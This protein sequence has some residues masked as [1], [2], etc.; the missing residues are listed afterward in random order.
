MQIDV[1]VFGLNALKAKFQN[2]QVKN[3]NWSQELFD[4]GIIL[5][6][7]QDLNFRDQGRPDR[8]VPTQAALNRNGMTLVNTGRLR[9]SVSI[10]GNED[11][12]FTLKPLSLTIS[13]DVP[14]AKYHQEER[15]FL[16]IQEEDIRNMELIMNKAIERIF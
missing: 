9:R 8:W 12:I 13:S 6:R 1:I 5:L 2:F 14:Y 10:L 4:I 11:N 3:R 7:S 15:P 16:M